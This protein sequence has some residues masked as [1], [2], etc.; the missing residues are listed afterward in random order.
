MQIRRLLSYSAVALA[1]VAVGS[2]ALPEPPRQHAP[3][4]P[5]PVVGMPDYGPELVALLF[6]A[7]LADPRGGRRFN[8]EKQAATYDSDGAYRKRWTDNA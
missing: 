7:G 6:D 8:I 1:L 4:Q 5:L 3:W 2:A